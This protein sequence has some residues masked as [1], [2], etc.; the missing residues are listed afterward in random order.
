MPRYDYVCEQCKRM[1]EHVHSMK[2]TPEIKCPDCQAPMK[3]AVVRNIA[4]FN[5]KGGSASIH[6]REKRNRI[7]KQEELGKR[8]KERW[9][10]VGGVKPNIA[11]VEQESWSDCQKLAKECGLNSE[12]YTPRVEQEK[13]N[14]KK[15]II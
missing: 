10:E 9:G 2:E 7:N 12:S 6:W 8:Q 1:D 3:R 11:G 14:K 5:I 13:K 4:G 15:L